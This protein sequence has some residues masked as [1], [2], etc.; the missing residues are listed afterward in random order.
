[1]K[2]ITFILVLMICA[3]CVNARNGNFNPQQFHA[4]LQKFITKEARL[5]PKEA[6]RFF[7][8]YTELHKKKRALFDKMKTY[9]H[10]KPATDEECKRVIQKT[11]ELDLQIKELERQ[12][13]NKFM[14]ILPAGKVY[15][16]LKAEHR[17]HHQALKKA[18]N[19]PGKKRR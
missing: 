15:D 14:K 19:R 2:K 1:M 8:L 9:R 16:V 18:G 10:S 5:T 7:P 17:F 11:D 4:E 12:Y 6:A 13:H 3:V